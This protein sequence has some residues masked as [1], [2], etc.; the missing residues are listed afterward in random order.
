MASWIIQLVLL[1]IERRQARQRDRL[2]RV[3]VEPQRL[4]RAVADLVDDSHLRQP[5]IVV[6]LELNRHLGRRQGFDD[7]RRL[8]EVEHRLAI[9]LNRDAE[10]LRDRVSC[11]RRPRR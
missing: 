5:E 11:R 10:P 9:G 8:D 1:Q 6:G 4:L 2:L 7:H 3:F